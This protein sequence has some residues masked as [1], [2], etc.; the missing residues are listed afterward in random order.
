MR[1]NF[2][3][4]AAVLIIFLFAAGIGIALL[5][6]KSIRQ[7][8]VSLGLPPIDQF[9]NLNYQDQLDLIKRAAEADPVKT[10]TYVKSAFLIN[11][12][13][14]EN[15]HEFAHLVGNGM[16]S[17]YG[18]DGITN[19][20]ETFGFG[21]FHGVSQEL[22]EQKGVSVV[23]EIQSRCIQ[24]F[25][26]DKTQNYNGCIHGMGHGLLTWEHFQ[27][28]KAL[29][30]C[31]NLDQLYQNY[32]YDGV[33]M[34]HASDLAQNEFDPAHSWQFCSALADKYHYNCARYQSQVFLTR[35]GIDIPKIGAYCAQAPDE[36]SSSTCS[37]SL[38][39]YITDMNLG[40]L[41]Q[42]LRSCSQIKG[43]GSY[44]CII[45]ASREV[46]FQTYVGW[47]ETAEALCESLPAN[48]KNQCPTTSQSLAPM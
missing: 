33:F 26:P 44:H 30:D 19:C 14:A 17:K 24:I 22:L 42:I 3:L 28:G 35:F 36:I 23:K 10:W 45:G 43:D 32:C 5:S 11:G 34:E 29:L 15:A 47:Q 4:P 25:P 7:Q 16:Y 18:L 9:R 21:C 27:V 48:W 46:A 38:G 20:D 6:S 13:Q 31:D 37:E 8:A 40:K 12:Q 2:N 41:P 1:I 39:Y